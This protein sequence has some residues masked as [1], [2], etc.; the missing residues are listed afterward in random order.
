MLPRS[1]AATLAVPEDRAQF[2]EAV[3][4]HSPIGKALVAP[5][6]QFIAVNP[7]L[8]RMLGFTPEHLQRLTFQAIT[9]PEDLQADLLLL[10]ELT[11]GAREHYSLTKRYLHRDGHV[12]W[13]QLDV[14]MVTE[15]GRHP[16][17][18][19]AQIQDVTDR[20]RQERA[21]VEQK[22]LARVTLMSIGDSV[23]TTDSHGRV[24]SLNAVAQHMTGWTLQDALGHPIEAVMPLFNEATGA[25]LINPLRVALRERRTV[26]MATGAMLISR[27]GNR[28]SVEDSAAPII[29]DDGSL[30]GAVMVFHDVTE[31]RALAAR[32]AHLA[33]HDTLT[34]L[35]NRTLMRDRVEHM[36]QLTQRRHTSFALAFLDLDGF[37]T[38]NDTYGHAAGDDLLRQVAGR[39]KGQLRA[40]DT[41]S[42]LGG[43]EFVILLPEP[44]ALNETQV[45]MDKVLAAIRAPFVLNDGEVRISSSAGVALYPQ[46]G[47]TVDNLMK[48]ADAAMYRAKAEGRNR[49]CFFNATLEAQ[50]REKFRLRQAV[51]QAVALEQFHLVYQPKV[52]GVTG[53]IIGVEAL[54]RWTLDGQPVPPGVFVPVAEECGSMPA[55]GTWVLRKACRQGQA[56]AKAGH[57]VRVAVN[58]S[59]LQFQ[60]GLFVNGVREVL[61]ET[62]LP[63]DLLELEVTEGVVMHGIER[64]RQVLAELRGIGVHVS[65]D[66]FGTGYSSLSYLH[67]LPIDTL[68]IDRSFVNGALESPQCDALLHSIINMGRALQLQ[69]LAEGVETEQERHHLTG[70][71]CE[72]MQGYLFSRPVAA[73][74]IGRLLSRDVLVPDGA[75]VSKR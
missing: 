75:E 26:G 71:G 54:L 50:G 12:V 55:L 74:E 34:D 60:E 32:M 7:A 8:S 52:H 40:S 17:F 66:D 9:H 72:L 48:H 16:A 5:D 22:E 39:L 38:V 25:E 62:G 31:Q 24:T 30:L 37:K 49:V 69:V 14:S 35:P 56:W 53:K 15:E 20:L 65:I 44:I 1:T 28:Y 29:T 43:D 2:L 57:P 10:Q 33:Q 13:V 19:I 27:D 67:T 6:G 21:L 41:L 18:Y 58:V 3:F 23:I 70:A 47:A 63:A 4:R 42:R 46:D 45:V 36:I 73:D 11:C 64:V 68:K 51:Q 59:A 61:C